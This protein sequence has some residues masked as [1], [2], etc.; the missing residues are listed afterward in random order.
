[1]I[2][3]RCSASGIREKAKQEGMKTLREAAIIKA[4]HGETS[5]DE[6]I[7]ETAG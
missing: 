3:R 4:F 2:A 1:M 5:V 7:R 6:V